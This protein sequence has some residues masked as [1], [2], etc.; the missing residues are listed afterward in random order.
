MILPDGG[1][2]PYAAFPSSVSL[3]ANG[4]AAAGSELQ[5]RKNGGTWTVHTGEPIPI[6]PAESLEARNKATDPVLYED[7][8][9]TSAEFY[10]LTAGFTG[11]STATWG[12]AIG[13][14]NL[15][16][17]IDNNGDTVT[18]KHGNTKLDLGNGE[19]LDDGE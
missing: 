9:V 4:A 2:Y 5:Y 1:T 13:G 17:E 10:R 12:N 3:S 19:F 14:A 18:L 11:T 7:S 8:F 16:T 6:G 15:L